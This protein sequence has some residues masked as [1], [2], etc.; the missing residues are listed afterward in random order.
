MHVFI[1]FCN[2]CFGFLI[3][4]L[5]MAFFSDFVRFTMFMTCNTK[6]CLQELSGKLAEKGMAVYN[7]SDDTCFV[8]LIKI[9]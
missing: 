5:T 9:K 2:A 4:V 3:Y 6:H 7:P 1:H 8:K